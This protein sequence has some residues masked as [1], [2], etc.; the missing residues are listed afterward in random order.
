ML[1]VVPSTPQHNSRE[2]VGPRSEEA[3]GITT[4]I[5]AETAPAQQP[6]LNF[7][8]SQARVPLYASKE[9]GLL[10]GSSRIGACFRDP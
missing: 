1:A 4:D 5:G 3:Q 2:S 10:L 9:V 7:G 6:S 8:I